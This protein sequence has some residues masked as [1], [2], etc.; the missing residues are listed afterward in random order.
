M[1]SMVKPWWKHGFDIESF[2]QKRSKIN[3]KLENL[4]EDKNYFNEF[5]ITSNKVYYN[6]TYSINSNRIGIIYK[7]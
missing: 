1:E 2:R 3:K 6:T 5:M 4:F 7:E